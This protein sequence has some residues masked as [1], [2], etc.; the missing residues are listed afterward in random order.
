MITAKVL[1]FLTLVFGMFT[2]FLLKKLQE[3][4]GDVTLGELSDYIST[5]VSQKSI[6]VNRKSQTPSITSSTELINKWK[7]LKLK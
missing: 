1:S 6:V 7:G 3:T 4:K 5:E 2:Y